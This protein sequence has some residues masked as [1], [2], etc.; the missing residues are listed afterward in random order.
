M[1]GYIGVLDAENP[2]GHWKKNL[3]F[4]KNLIK[5]E[6]DLSSLRFGEKKRLSPKIKVHGLIPQVKELEDKYPM[7]KLYLFA[8]DI[9][10][11]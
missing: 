5:F 8:K 2:A 9:A 3:D 4:K 6:N 11:A 7:D 10:E 1:V